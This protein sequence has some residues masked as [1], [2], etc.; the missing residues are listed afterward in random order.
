MQVGA[1][2]AVGPSMIQEDVVTEAV[3]RI[4]ALA[5]PMYDE[6]IQETR[7]NLES[8]PD[9][10]TDRWR[11]LSSGHGMMISP[12]LVSLEPGKEQRYRYDEKFKI[13]ILPPDNPVANLISQLSKRLHELNYPCKFAE[14]RF[15]KGCFIGNA[16]DWHIDGNGFGPYAITITF[17][18][19]PDWSTRIVKDFLGDEKSRQLLLGTRPLPQA[20]IDDL[21]THSVPATHGDFHDACQLPHRSPIAPDVAEGVLGADDWRLFIRLSQK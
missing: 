2:Y 18:N 1:R 10:Y 5:S 20:F 8:D 15:E 7:Q 14:V 11:G 17:G 21:N 16:E 4:K 19:K 6:L 13:D 9:Y 12:H 3:K